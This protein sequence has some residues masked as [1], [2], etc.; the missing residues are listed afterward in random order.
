MYEQLN[1][2]PM[3]L[4]IKRINTSL[5]GAQY[6]VSGKPFKKEG[7]IYVNI[8]RIDNKHEACYDVDI[9]DFHAIPS[10]SNGM[11]IERLRH[12][13]KRLCE[14]EIPLKHCHI[15]DDEVS[16]LP[17]AVRKHLMM[18]IIYGA[19]KHNE[20]DIS[21][22]FQ[23]FIDTFMNNNNK[24]RPMTGTIAFYYQK[25]KHI[26]RIVE[27]TKQGTIKT[28]LKKSK[29][30]KPSIH[31]AFLFGMCMHVYKITSSQLKKRINDKLT[32]YKNYGK[33]KK[34]VYRTLDRPMQLKPTSS[35]TL[36]IMREML[37]AAVPNEKRV[38]ELYNQAKD[39]YNAS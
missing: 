17:R 24:P 5:E 39:A 6:K 11:K 9:K 3:N 38:L 19:R 8:T 13:T 20:L 33:D 22:G 34:D 15:L 28:V 12:N 35:L 1:T 18:P 21:L 4:K 29:T 27:K 32:P 14:E 30:D 2:I 36:Y 25:D 37:I 16:L 26:L 31:Y 7:G 23:G 10:I